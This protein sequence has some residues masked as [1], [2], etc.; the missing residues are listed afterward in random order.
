MSRGIELA[1]SRLKPSSQHYALQLTLDV[2]A[3]SGSFVNT[4]LYRMQC[5]V[6]CLKRNV[7]T[8]HD[9]NRKCVSDKYCM[10]CISLLT[11]PLDKDRITDY[12]T[13]YDSWDDETE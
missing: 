3:C 10:I 13:S 12:R 5:R 8:R 1:L 6:G 7:G 9:S 11:K 4:M 2:V